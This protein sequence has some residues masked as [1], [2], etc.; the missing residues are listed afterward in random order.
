MSI[1]SAMLSNHLILCHPLLHLPSFFSSIRVFSNESAL[2]IRW[3]KC[4]SFSI[5]PSKE[6]LWLSSFRIDWFDLFSVQRTQEAS[7][8]PVLQFFNHQFF[9]SQPSLWSK[10]TVDTDSS[11]EVERLAPWK[12]SW[13]RQRK[14]H[15][16]KILPVCSP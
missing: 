11:Y 4:W 7:P 13:Q 1:E 9:S 14:T 6:H 5:S 12:E 10:I 2:C 3:P 8:A 16:C 15:L